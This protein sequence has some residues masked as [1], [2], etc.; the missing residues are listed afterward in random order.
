MYRQVGGKVSRMSIRNA[1]FNVLSNLKWCKVSL[2]IEVRL[3][4]N[5]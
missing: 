5:L 1:G 4:L 2:P 3:E